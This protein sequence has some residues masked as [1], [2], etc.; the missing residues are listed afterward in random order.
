[1]RL[2]DERSD[3][4]HPRDSVRRGK[5]RSEDQSEDQHAAS[6]S[7]FDGA[8]ASS[9][10]FSS[11]AGGRSHPDLPTAEAPSAWDLLMATI[12]SPMSLLDDDDEMQGEEGIDMMDEVREL[13]K[14]HS[15]RSTTAADGSDGAS[16]END[17]ALLLLGLGMSEEEEKEEQDD[18]VEEAED[19]FIPGE[20][21]PFPAL[22]PTDST[23]FQISP[24]TPA[25]DNPPPTTRHLPLP[26]RQARSSTRDRSSGSL[27]SSRSSTIMAR[28][29][30]SRRI[31]AGE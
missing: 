14:A 1:M 7:S 20:S 31:E 17:V 16:D 9:T 23:R 2:I 8:D 26:P 18:A 30:P 28:G 22:T 12:A 15:S 6:T 24:T 10:D 11:E 27:P 13:C 3:D 25:L 19:D 29:H 5:R 21:L 4:L